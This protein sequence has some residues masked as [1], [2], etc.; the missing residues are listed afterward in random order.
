MQAAE[1]QTAIYQRLTNFAPLQALVGQRIYDD[2]PQPTQFPYVVIGEDTSI[3][4]S[5]DCTLGTES[6]ITIHAWSRYYGRIEAKRILQAVYD[7][8]NRYNL[9]I[10]GADCV[11]LI[12]EYQETFLDPDGITR[13]GVI[14]FRLLTTHS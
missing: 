11:N 8:L 3:D 7:G 13:H 9:P 12:S 4:W 1:I 2:V 5:Q 14:R 10:T 6:T